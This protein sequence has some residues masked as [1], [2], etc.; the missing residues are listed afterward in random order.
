MAIE[1]K[2]PPRS[3]LAIPPGETLLDVLRDRHI[4][5]RDLAARIG[6]SNLAIRE[7]CHGT[8]PITDTVALGLEAVFGDL[9]AEFWLR[10]Q[11]S[12]DLTLGRTA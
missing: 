10:L 9:S 12:Y 7:I 4:T 6:V 2:A 11:S 3:D 1:T 8:A 5:Q